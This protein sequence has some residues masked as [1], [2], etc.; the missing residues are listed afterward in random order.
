MP[1]T[2]TAAADDDDRR[3]DRIL[4]KALRDLSLSAIHRLL[5]QGDVLVDG[6]AEKADYRVKSGQTI[7]VNNVEQNLIPKKYNSTKEDKLS[8]N[9]RNSSVHSG[10]CGNKLDIIYEGAGLLILNK[11]EGIAVHGKNSL[12]DQVLNYLKPKLKPSLSF[13]PGPLHRLDKPSS[14]IIAFST[15]LE[16]ARFFSALLQERKV[17][18]HYL[19]IV[20][21]VI[22]KPEIWTDELS[23]DHK[24]KKTFTS[25]DDSKAKTAITKIKALAVG[26]GCTL[27]E[28]EIETGRTHQIRAQ[29]AA[30][31]HVLLGDI[32][33][34]SPK[35]NIANL[36][37]KK[38]LKDNGFFLHA[39][40][41][42][43]PH[44]STLARDSPLP[45]SIEAPL[46]ER[47]RKKLEEI[48]GKDYKFILKA[49]AE[50][51][52]KN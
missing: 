19:A 44:S 41:L 43:F 31:G 25:D 30:H 42:K 9:Y 8:G 38:D 39:W 4:R 20:E 29:A 26:S 47:F 10:P 21:G 3:L 33:Y 17:T 13:R 1:L 46:P 5:R 51:T 45:L 48:F 11:P 49:L 15:S 36:P 32:K 35:T 52:E 27:I 2:L 12:E 6:K 16:G 40:R 24:Q 22:K 28:A 7:T 37:C 23:R 18:K 50:S 14:G 34:G